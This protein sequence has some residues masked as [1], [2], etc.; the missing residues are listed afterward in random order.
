MDLTQNAVPLVALIV[1]VCGL[2]F[3]L[4]SSRRHEQTEFLFKRVEDLVDQLKACK[5][6]NKDLSKTNSNLERENLRLMREMF[7]LEEQ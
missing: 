1:S 7:S 6:T 5:E 4:F 2:L 3:Y